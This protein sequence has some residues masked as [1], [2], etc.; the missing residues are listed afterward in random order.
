MLQYDKKVLAAQ[1]D[2]TR[3]AAEIT[4]YKALAPKIEELANE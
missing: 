3:A 1:S 4:S 2:L